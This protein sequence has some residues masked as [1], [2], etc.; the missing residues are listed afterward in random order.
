MKAARRLHAVM[1]IL[2]ALV[3]GIAQANPVRWQLNMTPG[4]TDVS[5]RVHSLHNL[6]LWI[7][8]VIGVLVFV[9]AVVPRLQSRQPQ[10]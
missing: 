8:V 5:E 3:A 4:V 9:V 1:A 6:T 2:A 10:V 7:C